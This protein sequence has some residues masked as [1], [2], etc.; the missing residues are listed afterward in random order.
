VVEFRTPEDAQGTLG[1]VVVTPP[2]SGATAEVSLV[3]TLEHG[4]ETRTVTA[5]ATLTGQERAFEA[6]FHWEG[7]AAA[8]RW[9][10][11][12]AVH[13]EGRELRRQHHSRVL[14][15]GFTRWQ[16]TL[17]AGGEEWDPEA[18]ARDAG[19]AAPALP[20]RLERQDPSDP[21]FGELGEAFVVRLAGSWDAA[22]TEEIA[23]AVATFTLPSERPVAFAYF[24]GGP[25]E[26]WCGARLD[27]DVVA[28]GPAHPAGT[29]PT[30]R[31]TS[32]VTLG[33][34][35]HQVVFR[36]HRPPELH[37]GWW[38]LAAGVVSPEDGQVQVDAVTEP[39]ASAASG[40]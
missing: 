40:R 26:V 6:P 2:V 17:D 4:A 10:V 14:E 9:S 11:D 19:A 35:R 28:S 38:V 32:P 31:R 18:V 22:Q 7:P 25:V 3:W 20:W 23:W 8:R 33:P 34:G 13:W 29:D 39:P 21:D 16:V 1:W 5:D 15:P 37:P 36:C 30:P 27:P 24:S 12:V